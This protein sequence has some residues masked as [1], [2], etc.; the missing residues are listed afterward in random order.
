MKSMLTHVKQRDTLTK[1]VLSFAK[2]V[3]L[4][5]SRDFFTFHPDPNPN[6]NLDQ[7][8][9]KTAWDEF[10]WDELSGSLY[11]AST[12]SYETYMMMIQ[13]V[14]YSC[15]NFFESELASNPK[16]NRI[17]CRK[18]YFLLEFYKMTYF[19]RKRREKS[20]FS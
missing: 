15:M 16:I 10:S 7:L 1:V 9:H 3:R 6:P 19:L 14:F 5:T 8:C 18:I 11:F 4:F 17:T 20:I 13:S 12:Y 2:G